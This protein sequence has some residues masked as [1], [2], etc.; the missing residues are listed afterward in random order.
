MAL[1]YSEKCQVPSQGESFKNSPRVSPSSLVKV[2]VA[3]VTDKP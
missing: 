2:V 1:S 3:A